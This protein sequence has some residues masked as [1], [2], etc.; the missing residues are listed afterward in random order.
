MDYLK[1]YIKKYNENLEVVKNKSFDVSVYLDDN[2]KRKIAN[3]YT[4]D[5]KEQIFF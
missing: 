1:S 2:T 4:A 3:I 5:K